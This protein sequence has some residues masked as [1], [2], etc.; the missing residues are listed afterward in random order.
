[1]FRIT[2]FGIP[3]RIR[4]IK[5]FRFR[6]IRFNTRFRIRIWFEIWIIFRILL[7]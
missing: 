3:F 7:P 4:F 2:I 6:I 1:M 5:R